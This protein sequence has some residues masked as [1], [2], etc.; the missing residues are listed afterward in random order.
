VAIVA[1]FAAGIV[2]T[3]TLPIVGLTFV[4]TNASL[5]GT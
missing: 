4:A 5:S 1:A 3:W 2:G